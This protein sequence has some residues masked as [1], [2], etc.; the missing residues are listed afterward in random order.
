MPDATQETTR[1]IIAPVRTRELLQL[2]RLF[3]QA[4]R[5]HFTYFPKSTQQD[6]ITS[7]SL[8]KLLRANLDP[9]RIILVARSGGR[10]V[11]YC[12]GAVPRSGPAQLF[13][14]YVEPEFRGTNTG[15]SLLSRT[16]KLME[17]RGAA[18]V[19]IAT[20]DHRGYYERQGF[21]HQS[22]VTQHGIPMDIMAFQIR[23]K[24]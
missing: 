23:R 16:I 13:W 3:E 20:H 17:S 6:V 7:H 19:F 15:L 11:G 10:I 14:L 1:L 8:G 9:H 22:R 2:K 18:D 12:I 5:H 24:Q 4:V 21:K